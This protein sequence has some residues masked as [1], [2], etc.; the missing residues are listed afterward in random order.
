MVIFQFTGLSGAGKKNLAENVSGLLKQQQFSTAIIDGDV[1]HKTIC[2]DLGFSRE[3]RHK[4]KRRLGAA[5]FDLSK[6]YNVVLIAAIN[7]FEIIRQELSEKYGAK[8]IWIQC[9]HTF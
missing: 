2:K 8:T 4:N 7:P 6:K 3:D 9:T 5:A 1:Y